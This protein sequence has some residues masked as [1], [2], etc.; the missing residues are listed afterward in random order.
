[1]V[2]QVRKEEMKFEAREKQRIAD[3]IA[4][5]EK[6]KQ[7]IEQGKQKSLDQSLIDKLAIDKLI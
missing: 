7:E 1:M 5:G 3:V 4:R 6:F 2:S